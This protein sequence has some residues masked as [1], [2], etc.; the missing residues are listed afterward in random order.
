MALNVADCSYLV[1][2][3]A[4]IITGPAAAFGQGA[5][6]YSVLYAFPGFLLAWLIGGVFNRLAY[7]GLSARNPESLKGCLYEVCPLLSIAGTV[8]A[9]A[10]TCSSLAALFC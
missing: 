2:V 1:T 7:R 5:G 3:L 6:W 9:A 4:G 10:W 8:A